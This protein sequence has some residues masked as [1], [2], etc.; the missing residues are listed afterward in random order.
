MKSIEEIIVE[1]K[2]S[3][4]QEKNCNKSTKNKQVLTDEQNQIQFTLSK[5]WNLIN[6]NK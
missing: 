1:L 3:I 4:S 6:M 2:D 5:A